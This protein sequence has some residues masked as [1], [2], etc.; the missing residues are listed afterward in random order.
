MS[1]TLYADLCKHF[2]EASLL[3]SEKQIA[4]KK[5]KKKKIKTPT[6]LGSWFHLDFCSSCFATSQT[7]H[8]EISW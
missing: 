8:L 3:H 4:K 2:I 7:D 5:K 6:H 1:S